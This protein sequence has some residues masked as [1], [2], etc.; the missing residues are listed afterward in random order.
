MTL[1]VEL[2]LRGGGELPVADGAGERFVAGV[3]P[4]MLLKVPVLPEALPALV[5]LERLLG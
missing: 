2:V 5:A 1:F 4:S 3:D